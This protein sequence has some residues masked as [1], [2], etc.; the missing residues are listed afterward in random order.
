M[1]ADAHR[2]LSRDTPVRC[3]VVSISD[4]RTEETDASG[5]TLSDGLR[6]AGHTLEFYRI[7]P[8]DP[9][10]IRAVLLHLAGRVEV[11]VTTGGTGIGRRDRTVEVAERLIQKPLPGFGELFRMLS[12]QE[13]G[14]AAM[15][16]R[17][18]AGV[19]GHEDGP[20]ETLLFCCPGSVDA[21]RLALDRL[22][23]PELHHLVWEIVRRPAEPPSRAPQFPLDPAAARV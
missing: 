5:K 22:L 14:A 4:T 16:S 15:L 11:V 9:E 6:E 21:V 23:L 13:V 8:D 3:A 1:S 20:P 10:A 18:T 7:V 17:A 2:R 19:Y 12:F